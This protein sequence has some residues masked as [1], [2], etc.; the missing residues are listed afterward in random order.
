[1]RVGRHTYGQN[2]ITVRHWGE[3]ATLTI[4]NF[5]S[6][7]EDVTVFLGG[8]HR[9]DWVTTFP[10]PEFT[11][12]WKAARGVE[13][14]PATKGDVTIGNDVWLGSGSTIM[15]GVTIGDGAVIGARSMVTRDVEPYAIVAGNPARMI[16][17][18][19]SPGVVEQLLRIAWW[20]WSDEQVETAIPMLCDERIERFVGEYGDTPQ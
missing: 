15:S 11:Y 6:I 16:R 12:R 10:F 20:N 1:M 3:D 17:P 4:G 14:H 2:R 7:A 5:C 19:F 9:V 13:G 8:N 18:R